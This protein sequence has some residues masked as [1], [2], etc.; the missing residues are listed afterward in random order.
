MGWRIA[1]LILLVLIMGSCTKVEMKAL[2]SVD[3]TEIGV[4]ESLKIVLDYSPRIGDAV[5]YIKIDGKIVKSSEEFPVE[6]E[7][8]PESKDVGEH[9]ISGFVNTMFGEVIESSSVTVLV[10]DRTP[11]EFQVEFL[12]NLGSPDDG[13][14]IPVKKPI[15]MI[16]NIEDP[17][18][19]EFTLRWHMDDGM[20]GNVSGL[21]KTDIIDIGS[22]REDR[23]YLLK[24][25]V[26]N[27]SG[28]ST[29]DT[30]EMR[31]ISDD[32][33]PRVFMDIPEKLDKN[34]P[35]IMSLDL[36]D[37]SE[38]KEFW[39]KIDGLEVHRER[40]MGNYIS[41][42]K[43]N[44]G[45]QSE[46]IHVVTVYARDLSGKVG[47]STGELEVGESPI[48]LNLVL[49]DPGPDGWYSP[50]ETVNIRVEY[51]I[52]TPVDVDIFVDG[53]PIGR[54]LETSW[55]AQSGFHTVSALA[56]LDENFE[57]SHT[58]V[59]V[60]DNFP[61]SLER[62]FLNGEEVN[63]SQPLRVEAKG[64]IVDMVFEDESGF[65]GSEKLVVY[66]SNEPN[67][68]D[69]IEVLSLNPMNLSEDG[70]HITYRLAYDFKGYAGKTVYL[71][72]SGIS[73]IEGNGMESPV[74]SLLFE[75]EE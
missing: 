57:W 33:P 2:L 24:I 20:G 17:E 30:I 38:L 45:H 58:M 66:L 16:V 64:N 63:P 55:I 1:S 6:Y 73:D 15:K 72:I 65:S 42:Y 43:I 32:S 4:G 25:D 29:S 47:W 3:E 59:K 13:I 70:K 36:Q 62:V 40:L 61:P 69:L 14:L 19:E 39:V 26:V 51:A 48:G 75:V 31:G 10:E 44:L 41:G 49:S 22:L 54:G 67:L 60:E 35:F 18:S 37:D 7:W 8:I 11:P 23:V 50:G 53:N 56:T 71:A 9:V 34:S 5:G 74:D 52:S 46:G 68:G 21:G 27:E 28:L 12:P